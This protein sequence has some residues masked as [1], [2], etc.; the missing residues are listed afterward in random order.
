MTTESQVLRPGDAG[1]PRR[2]QALGCSRELYVR[3]NLALAQDGNPVVAIVGARAATADGMARAHAIGRH[4]AKRGV[5]VV[6][7]GALGIDGAAHRGVL[8]GE[9]PGQKIVVLGSGVDVAYPSRHAQLFEDV[10]ARG[11]LLVSMFPL[12][13]QPRRGTFLQRNELI[14]ALADAVVVIEAQVKSG[15]LATAA[16]ARGLGRS[17][18]AAPGSP[19]CQRL[20]GQGA[21]LVEDGEDV[22]RILEGNPRMPAPVNLDED[23]QRVRDALVQG[24]K[25]IDQIVRVTGLS[26]RAVLRALP[27]L[28][29][30]ARLQ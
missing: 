7:G 17:L 27:Q 6:S 30:S 13:M 14:A 26:V 5:H 23:A 9:G 12:G 15:S 4:L 3:G 1:Y 24:A 22:V 11:G 20:V 8:A 28:E 18:G 25:G 16:H 10:V 2:L 19:G 21:G 29:S